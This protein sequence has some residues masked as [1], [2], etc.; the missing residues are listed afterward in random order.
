MMVRNARTP[1]SGSDSADAT[2][3]VWPKPAALADWVIR[4]STAL[5][6]FGAGDAFEDSEDDLKAAAVAAYSASI[7][8]GLPLSE[9]KLAETFGKTSRR[10]AR[11]R[12]NE[13]R[14][15]IMSA[16]A[17]SQWASFRR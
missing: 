14:P 1:G 17:D 7:E 10:W 5:A 16:S 13:A 9:R 6:V 8:N 4:L 3:L 11:N 2:H 12:M 15:A